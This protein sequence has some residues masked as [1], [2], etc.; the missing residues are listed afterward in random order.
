MKNQRTHHPRLSKKSVLDSMDNL[1]DPI[2]AA[3]ALD[4]QVTPIDLA[5]ATEVVSLAA[6]WRRYRLDQGRRCA[7][8]RRLELAQALVDYPGTLEK[9]AKLQ[10][11]W[12]PQPEFDSSYWENTQAGIEFVSTLQVVEDYYAAEKYRWFL[13]RLHRDLGTTATSANALLSPE[14]WRTYRTLTTLAEDDSVAFWRISELIENLDVQQ[15]G[16]EF[17]Y[18][19]FYDFW[20][21]NRFEAPE[22]PRPAHFRH[23]PWRDDPSLL[24][25]WIA[26]AVDQDVL[27]V[28]R[29]A[30]IFVDDPETDQYYYAVSEYFHERLRWYVRSKLIPPGQA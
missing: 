24:E 15:L 11:G 14:I 22:E 6:Y 8:A 27:D 3:V 29:K 12:I 18:P 30:L 16:Y 2:F 1:Q 20:L 17:E 13:A 23:V 19:E 25:W 21:F 5:N 9:L 10:A 28:A 26:W 4:H 7:Y